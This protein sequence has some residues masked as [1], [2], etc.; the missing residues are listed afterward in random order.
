MKTPLEIVQGR[1]A[2]REGLEWVKA[3]P[4]L[5]AGE[6][7]DQA[8]APGQEELRAFCFFSVAYGG[9][10]RKDCPGHGREKT[11]ALLA[12]IAKLRA[13]FVAECESE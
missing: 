8:T 7:F 4:T 9:G 3:R 12:E 5:T 13:A 10:E 11:P 1:L 6:V 2:C